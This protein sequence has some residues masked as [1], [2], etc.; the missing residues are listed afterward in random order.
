MLLSQIICL[1]VL[2]SSFCGYMAKASCAEANTCCGPDEADCGVDIFANGT[3]RCFCDRECVFL[4]DCCS[5]YLEFCGVT[6][7]AKNVRRFTAFSYH[8]KVAL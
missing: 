1:F 3:A 6:G 5:D 2:V 8:P 7:E 4:N